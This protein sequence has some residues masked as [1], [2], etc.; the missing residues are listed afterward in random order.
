MR[1]AEGVITVSAFSRSEIARVF[2][3]DPERITV[4]PNAVD[5][6]FAA[7]SGAPGPVVP[8]YVLAIGNLQPRKNLITLIRAFRRLS[9][10]RPDLAERLVIVGQPAYRGSRI[11]EEARDLV[12]RGRVV[13]TGY[14]SDP[15]MASALAAATLFAHP[16][17]YEGFGLP[18]IEAMACGA[19][20]V[21]SDIPVVREVAGEAAALVPPLDPGA[22]AA[23]LGR[24]LDDGGERARLAERGRAR[25]RA[26]TPE[27]SAAPVV[28]AIERA[29]GV[30]PAADDAPPSAS[31]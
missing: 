30:T 9:D 17:T 29:V 3:I 11:V 26:Y 25:A 13:F 19:P 2:G 20:V 1:R 16:S 22:W 12:A 31:G 7:S 18:L 21:A 8:P 4:A 6:V 15:P 10:E 5:P 24:L 23:T 27:A 28:A 14:L